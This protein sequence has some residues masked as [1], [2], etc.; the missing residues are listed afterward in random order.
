MV[1][2]WE[3]SSSMTKNIKKW[4]FWYNGISTTLI[5]KFNDSAFA[6]RFNRKRIGLC[7]DA[8]IDLKDF[9]EICLNALQKIFFVFL[10]KIFIQLFSTYSPHCS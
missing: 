10:T 1:I 8:G 5:D 7:A 9:L 6:V 4:I 3:N 2:S